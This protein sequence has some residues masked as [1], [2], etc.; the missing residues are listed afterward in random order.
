MYEKVC[1][2]HDDLREEKSWDDFLREAADHTYLLL[3]H[4]SKTVPNTDKTYT[5]FRVLLDKILNCGYFHKSLPGRGE[6]QPPEQAKS[7]AGSS[8]GNDDKEIGNKLEDQPT[9]LRPE[10][11]SSEKPIDE[12]SSYCRQEVCDQTVIS[13]LHQSPTDVIGPT[14]GYVH[15]LQDDQ[16]TCPPKEST[17]Y[18]EAQDGPVYNVS[19]GAVLFAQPSNPTLQQ[20]LYPNGFPNSFCSFP[21]TMPQAAVCVADSIQLAE[22]MKTVTVS[23]DADVASTPVSEPVTIIDFDSIFLYRRD[24]VLN[25]GNQFVRGSERGPVPQGISNQNTECNGSHAVTPAVAAATFVTTV[26]A[27]LSD[28]SSFDS[29]F[30]PVR[31]RGGRGRGGF[32]GGPR[33]SSNV[34]FRG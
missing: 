20:N 7:D 16:T 29:Q 17:L 32:R 25:K 5:D 8:C 11:S 19:G 26:P 30:K 2:S 10:I 23:C 21:S 22:Q 18:C 12:G 15:F 33:N 13:Q 4:S 28:P 14:Q 27:P 24:A 31:S 34:P 9:E 3:N 6:N 1:P